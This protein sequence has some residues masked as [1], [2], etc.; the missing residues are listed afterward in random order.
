MEL[1]LIYI[2]IIFIGS[3]KFQILQ[4]QLEGGTNPLSYMHQNVRKHQLPE[5]SSTN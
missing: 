2:K 5:F 3:A 1:F 4:Y